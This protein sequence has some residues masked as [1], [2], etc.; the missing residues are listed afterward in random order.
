MA[1]LYFARGV[2][3]GLCSSQA[4]L[5]SRLLDARVLLWVNLALWTRSCQDVNVIN[6]DTRGLI[7]DRL[8]G[9]RD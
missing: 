3:D 6:L 5:L 9:N 2:V 1:L 4:L 8:P 7:L